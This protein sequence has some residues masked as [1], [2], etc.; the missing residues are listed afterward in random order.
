M[1]LTEDT[2]ADRLD[3]EVKGVQK[4]LR[5]WHMMNDPVSIGHL[6]EMMYEEEPQTV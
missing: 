2:V 3:N 1:R 4:K 5:V 6:Y